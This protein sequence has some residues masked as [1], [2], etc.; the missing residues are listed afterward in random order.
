MD[1]LSG[2][3]LL[4][5]GDVRNIAEV[6]INGKAVPARLWAPYTFRLSGLLCKGK[7]ELTVIVT[8]TLANRL[9]G[10]KQPSGLIGPV[11]L[12]FDRTDP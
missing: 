12:W 10:C 9:D 7:N 1:A 6:F 2:N 11:Q 5:L 8:N 4:D 3:A